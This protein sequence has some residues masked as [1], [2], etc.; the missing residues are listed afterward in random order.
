MFVLGGYYYWDDGH[1]YPTSDYDP[2]Y[3]YDD[4]PIYAYGNN[5]L[6]VRR[7]SLPRKWQAQLPRQQ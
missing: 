1:W 7:V 4:G 2:N 3:S 5:D 6:A